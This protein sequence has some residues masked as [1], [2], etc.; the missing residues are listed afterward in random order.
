MSRWVYYSSS[1]TLVGRNADQI[2]S[3]RMTD[4]PALF[5]PV[6]AATSRTGWEWEVDTTGLSLESSAM[7]VAEYAME[8]LR[9]DGVSVTM[10]RAR[11][12]Q[13]YV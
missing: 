11:M 4:E 8:G 13:R 1:A 5:F 3:L 6:A 7:R 10:R 2:L 12:R 9:R